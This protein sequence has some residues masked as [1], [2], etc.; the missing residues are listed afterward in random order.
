MSV[1]ERVP[2]IV[3]VHRRQGPQ[4]QLNLP[5]VDACVTEK[6]SHIAMSLCRRAV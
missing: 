6:P 2:K 4:S 5:Q 3:A 1:P